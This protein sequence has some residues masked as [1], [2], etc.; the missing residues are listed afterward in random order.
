VAQGVGS[1]AVAGLRLVRQGAAAIASCMCRVSDTH[2]FLGSRYRALPGPRLRRDWGSPPPHLHRDWARPTAPCHICTGTGLTASTSAPGLG[3]LRHICIGNGLTAATSA[4][5][6]G[7]PLA[8]SAPGLGSPLATSAPGLGSRR[9]SD[10]QL[11]EYSPTPAAATP[12]EAPA[13]VAAGNL[14]VAV[15]R[16]ATLAEGSH[17]HIKPEPADGGTDC[18]IKRENP[19]VPAAAA[20]EDEDEDDDALFLF[21]KPTAAA[22]APAAAAAAAA[23]PSAEGLG[24]AA[25]GV[26]K[27]APP[28]PTT[29]APGP[30]PHLR[31]D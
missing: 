18:A 26:S 7:S 23:G 3:S 22:S 2:L 17:V 14:A 11:I 24:R 15:K 20:D 6:L 12:A 21:G 16:E 28:S 25:L 30:A 8:T 29:S 13:A 27:C 9:C 19:A 1:R 10:S 4:P 5:G 31:R